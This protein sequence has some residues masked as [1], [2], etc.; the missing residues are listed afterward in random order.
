MADE[1]QLPV[2]VLTDQYTMDSMCD[3]AGFDLS[4]IPDSVHIVRTEPDYRRYLLT[5]DGISPRGIPGHGK[6]LVFVDSDEHDERGN[7]TEAAEVRRQMVEKR[8]HKGEL[9]KAMAL[10]PEWIGPAQADN[11]VDLLGVRRLNPFARQSQDSKGRT[12]RFCTFPR[13]T[14][15]RR[16][17]AT[18]GQGPPPDP[19]RRKFHRSVRKAASDGIGYSVGVPDPEIRRFTLCRRGV[20]G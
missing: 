7:I 17:H 1:L 6:G 2:V 10:P 3:V 5:K 12:W 18:A 9:A 15:W 20:A 11:L 19:G 14:P 4:S 16:K 13:Y 8:L